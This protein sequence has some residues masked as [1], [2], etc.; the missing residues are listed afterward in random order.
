MTITAAIN[1]LFRSFYELF[2]FILGTAYNTVHSIV[3]A[4]VSLFTGFVGLIGDVLSGTVGVVNGVSKFVVGNAVVIAVVA[5]A[6]FAYVRYT[7]QGKQV[8][9]SVAGKKVN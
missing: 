9:S 3:F 2:S 1:D 5:A 8:A 6:G 7:Q 4:F